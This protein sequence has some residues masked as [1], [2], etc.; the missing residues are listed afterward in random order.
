MS[1]NPQDQQPAPDSQ[2]LPVLTGHID[3]A[4]IISAEAVEKNPTE[5]ALETYEALKHN[6]P[7]APDL[8]SSE[9]DVV[10]P[11]TN[12]EI[13][14]NNGVSRGRQVVTGLAAAAVLTPIGAAL[15]PSAGESVATT[16]TT[17]EQVQ[18]EKT[19]TADTT[20]LTPVEPVEM[21]TDSVDPATSQTNVSEIS[22]DQGG[23][24]DDETVLVDSVSSSDNDSATPEVD[25]APSVPEGIKQEVVGAEQDHGDITVSRSTDL[26]SYLMDN[27]DITGI[28]PTIEINGETAIYTFNDPSGISVSYSVKYNTVSSTPIFNDNHPM[29]DILTITITDAN[30]NVVHVKN[31][32]DNTRKPG[33]GVVQVGKDPITTDSVL[34]PGFTLSAKE[35]ADEAALQTA[36]TDYVLRNRR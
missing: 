1:P 8:T 14:N 17:T 5:G 12:S 6:A 21:Y 26:V 19:G 35:T 7:I 4:S 32:N 29:K 13:P 31:S 34:F 22:P 36:D 28:D 30:G 20:I 11:R 9:F 2:G 33:V 27:Q 23:D 15:L 18:S 16:D 25:V 3:E 10:R 24:V